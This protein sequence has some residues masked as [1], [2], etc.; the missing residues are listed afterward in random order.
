M[1]IQEQ[2][3]P[4]E[5]FDDWLRRC[6]IEADELL[7]PEVADRIHEQG[8]AAVE[9]YSRTTARRWLSLR[10]SLLASSGNAGESFALRR[11]IWSAGARSRAGRAA[12]DGTGFFV[13]SW[14]PPT[15]RRGT[16]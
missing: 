10:Q 1:A 11:A 6:L 7:R 2:H 12:V 13:N 3:R 14:I 15:P 4:F 16:L 5:S 9:R 8:A